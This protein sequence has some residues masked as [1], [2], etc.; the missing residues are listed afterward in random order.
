VVDVCVVGRPH[1][2]L[3][4][5]PVAFVVGELTQSELDRFL[6]QRGL[7]RYKWPEKV[8]LLDELPLS[9]PGKVNRKV[10]S[11]HARALQ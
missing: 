4:E 6:E 9:G 5:I 7:A 2:D 1:P 3:G 10:L 11:E 8:H